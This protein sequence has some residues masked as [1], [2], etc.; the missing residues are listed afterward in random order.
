MCNFCKVPFSQIEIHPNG[1]VYVCC[2]AK[3]NKSIGNIYETDFDKIWYSD[4]AKEMRREIIK[5]RNYKYCDLQ[6]CNPLDN[7]EQ[8]KLDLIDDYKIDYS[9]TP[10]YPLYVKFCHEKHCNIKC[11]TCRDDFITNTKEQEEKLNSYIK[12]TYLPIL[13]N[14]KVVSLNGSGEVFA[15][16]HCTNLVKA[17][18]EE[19]PDIKF[20]FHTNAL[21][22]SEKMLKGLNIEDKV[23]AVDV[24]MHAYSRKTYNKIM[25][26][27]NYDIVRRNLQ[28]LSGLRRRGTL[29]TLSLYFV[30]QKMN[31]KE[32]PDFINFAQKINAEVYFWEYRN[33]HNN[34]GQKNYKKVAIY[35]KC[36]LL[37]NDFAKLLQD[38]IFKAKNCHLNNFLQ[39]VKPISFREHLECIIS[40]KR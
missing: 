4:V 14:C 22:C 16:K 11:V 25:R 34:W 32:M 12:T 30:V 23:V 3:N 24:S 5:N 37:Y 15:S 19:Y 6:I 2:P 18:A 38:P 35:D 10:D 20:D 28:Y 40:G 8:D 9:E 26:G 13:K 36:H 33:W 17:I 29:K 27:S 39:K 21:L 7:I 31:Y 1:N